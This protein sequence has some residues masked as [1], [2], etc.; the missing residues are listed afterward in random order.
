MGQ[1]MNQADYDKVLAQAKKCEKERMRKIRREIRLCK[2]TGTKCSFS[3][4][5]LLDA[6]C[7]VDT[8]RAVYRN[9]N[10]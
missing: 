1:D 6:G 9:E 10:D 2:Q 5:T 8:I 7:S 3:L 4:G